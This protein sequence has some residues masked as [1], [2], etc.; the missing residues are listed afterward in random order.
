MND[1]LANDSK[2][3]A[4]DK[5]ETSR[6]MSQQ[7]LNQLNQQ[8][9]LIQTQKSLLHGMQNKATFSIES[10]SLVSTSIGWFLV[11]IPFGKFEV[12]NDTF[13]GIGASAPLAQI[14]IGKQKNDQFTWNN[15]SVTIQEIY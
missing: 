15:S 1:S 5:Y 2:S 10:G 11:G 14:L 7:E 3:S 4:G 12:K 8:I 6:E 9:R 13:F